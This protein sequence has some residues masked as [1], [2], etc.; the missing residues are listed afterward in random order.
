[1]LFFRDSHG[2]LTQCGRV[3]VLVAGG[4]RHTLLD[5]DHKLKFSIHP[6]AMKM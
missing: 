4:I 1:M 6:G 2:L 5:E 3:W